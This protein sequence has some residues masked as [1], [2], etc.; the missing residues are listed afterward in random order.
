MNQQEIPRLFIKSNRALKTGDYGQAVALFA[1][2]S[3][4]IDASSPNY[5]HI[6]NRRSCLHRN[7]LLSQSL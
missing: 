5:F 3:Q 7:S 2:L 4:E 1:Q 6:Q